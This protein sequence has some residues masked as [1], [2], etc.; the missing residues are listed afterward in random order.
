[1]G[2]IDF[3]VPPTFLDFPGGGRYIFQEGLAH[4]GFIAVSICVEPFFVVVPF[5]VL[6]ER[7]ILFCEKGSHDKD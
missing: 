1:M 2:W 6:E 3:Y 7:Y 5:K 4:I